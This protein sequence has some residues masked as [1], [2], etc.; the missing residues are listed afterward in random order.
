MD[1]YSILEVNRT[2]TDSD[3][4]KAYRKLAMEHHPDKNE[5]NRK[6]EDK[7]KQISEAYQTLGD[8]K[9]RAE[10]DLKTTRHNTDN[11][12]FG[13]DDFVKNGFKNDDFRNWRR[14]ENDKARKSQGRTHT[15]PNSDY[16]NITLEKEVA[17]ADSLKGLELVLEFSR[18]K[19]DYSG[20]VGSLLQFT[21]I[22]ESKEVTVDLDLKKICLNIKE[23][24][25]QYIAKVRLSKLGN[26][27]II[28]NLNMWGEIEQHPLVG[29][30]HL[31]INFKVDPKIKL[32]GTNIIQKVDISLYDILFNNKKLGI[33]TILGKRYNVNL[34]KIS[35]LSNIDMTI[36]EEG[37][38]G[39]TGK[40]GD[41][42]IK[43]EVLMPALD[44][45]DTEKLAQ[46]KELL[47]SLE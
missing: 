28:D 47:G 21:K 18:D 20:K 40:R 29:D 14:S 37:L 30:V 35:N 10:Y 6:A 15:M 43:F 11:K 26:E 23:V 1:Y 9:K 22:Q 3:I 39:E 19:I 27:D 34:K 7:F 12:G 8:S 5:G 25:G 42:L 32:S 31:N 24:D 45:L 46:I 16:L 17:L 4:K 44:T 36:P 2:A 13:F 33:E 38:F 41:Y